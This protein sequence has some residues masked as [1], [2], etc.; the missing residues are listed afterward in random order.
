MRWKNAP[1]ISDN[2][3]L[4]QVLQKYKEERGKR[5]KKIILPFVSKARKYI[6]LIMNEEAVYELSKK[7]QNNTKK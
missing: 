3:E 5:S 6:F 7:D 4:Y 1:I 2:K